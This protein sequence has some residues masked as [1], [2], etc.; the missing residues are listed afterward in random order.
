MKKKL[1]HILVINL[2]KST[3]RKRFVEKKF[4]VW[5][6][7]KLIFLN[8]IDGNEKG[9]EFFK[10]R[11]S[12]FSNVLQRNLYPG[13]LGCLY[14]HMKAWEFIIRNQLENALILEDDID[15]KATEQEFI[16][17]LK[18]IPTNF[19]LIY[20]GFRGFTKKSKTFA[21]KLI[22]YYPFKYLIGKGNPN[23]KY[24]ELKNLYSRKYN[25]YWDWAGAH[26]GSH[27]YIITN[28]AAKQLLELSKNKTEPTDILIGLYSIKNK[29][30]AYKSKTQIFYPNERFYSTIAI[31]SKNRK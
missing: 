27:A 31:D 17:I 2:P 28:K 9:I 16:H 4:Q 24:S 1:N 12:I 7:F 10:N 3:E 25:K 8:A 30:L 21:F 5:N 20:L 22:F 6:H 11:R 26:H 23:Y 29:V 15:F 13:E 19:D 14:S 18:T